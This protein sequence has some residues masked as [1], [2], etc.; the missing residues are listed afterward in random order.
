MQSNRIK[1]D[2]RPERMEQNGM[3]G[4]KP[5]TKPSMGSRTHHRL[6]EKFALSPGNYWFS[7]CADTLSAVF[8]LH[9]ESQVRHIPLAWTAT[10]F[11]IGF[12]LWQL[13]E[14]V[15]HRW[16]YHQPA[17]IFGDGHR[18]HHNQPQV[19]IGMPWFMT[20]ATV[21][22]IWYLAGVALGIPLL[23][24]LLAGWLIGFVWYSLV[25]HSL[26]HWRFRNGWMRR[27]EAYHRIHHQFPASNF[28]VT[29]RYW[30]GI[31]GTRYRK[32]R[33]RTLDAQEDGLEGV[34]SI[35]AGMAGK[36]VVGVLES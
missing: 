9:W 28:G 16:I 13:T 24:S 21:F 34:S 26:H 5:G 29:M 8:F 30:D 18:I 15:F 7:F 33:S 3:A 14:Y 1:S 17:G 25:H 2:A 27:L 10:G 6:L 23:S 4:G 32:T 36:S 19:L 35:R 11:G 12:V 31:F 22:G 20:T